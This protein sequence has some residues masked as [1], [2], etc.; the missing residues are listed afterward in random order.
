MR[1]RSPNQSGENHGRLK[2]KSR[3]GNRSLTRDQCAFCK[4]TGHWKKDCPE[5]KKKKKLKEKSVKPSEMNVAKSD[6][7]DSD[8]SAFS[9]SITP[10]VCYSDA[11]EWLL[12]TGATYQICPRRE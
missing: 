9:F 7:N 8:S 6:R 4:L 11:S 10:S 3:Y 2:S 12:D 5:L 1:G